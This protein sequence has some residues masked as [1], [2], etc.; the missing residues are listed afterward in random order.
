MSDQ[1]I[2]LGKLAYAGALAAS[3]GW[4]DLLPGKTIYPYDEVEAAFQDYAAR[5]NM[6]DWDYWAD[7]FTPQCLYVDHHF[8]VFHTA[9]EVATWMTPLMATQPDLR[10]QVGLCAILF[11]VALAAYRFRRRTRSLAAR[12]EIVF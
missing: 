7:I 11:V 8:G 12:S 9:K 2:D 4:Q 1:N 6:D 10:E 3:R 5:A